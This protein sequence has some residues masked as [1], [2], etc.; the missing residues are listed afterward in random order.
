MKRFEFSLERLLKVKRQLK[1][2]AELE[3]Q[4]AQEHLTTAE[5]TLASLRAELARISAQVAAAVGSAFNPAHWARASGKTEWLSGLIKLA[6]QKLRDA[7]QQLDAAEQKL[8]QLAIEVE[9]LVTLRQQQLD[10][11]R[12]ESQKATQEQLDELG[13]RRWQAARD[14][15]DESR[16]AG[17]TAPEEKQAL[18]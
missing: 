1:K 9:A 15:A 4:T 13:L 7:K 18:P 3:K 17:D 14:K 10:Q 11:W 5:A 12:Y 16:D 6:E 2:Q 8:K